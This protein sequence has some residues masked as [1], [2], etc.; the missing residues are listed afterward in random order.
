MVA[1]DAPAPEHWR[2]DVVLAPPTEE[3]DLDADGHE[4]LVIGATDDAM[5]RTCFALVRIDDEGF[6]KEITPTYEALGGDGC[7][8]GFTPEPELRAMVVVRFPELAGR[9]IPQ[10]SVPH[11]AGDDGEWVARPSADYLQRERARRQRALE[12]GELAPHRAAVELAALAHLEG[13]ET[14]AQLEAFDAALG[15][16][17]DAAAS[18]ARARIAEGWREPTD[19]A[20]EPE[21][22]PTET[23]DA[24]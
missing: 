22:E 10:V 8:E 24:R 19:A 20:E 5:D 12:S 15:D 21:P 13:A 16:A 1:I 11:G 9:T 17:V 18:E 23:D 14:G 6:A 4:E 3:A 7:V 2:R